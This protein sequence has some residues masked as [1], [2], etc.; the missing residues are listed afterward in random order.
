M[1]V[2]FAGETY[3]TN[4]VKSIFLAGPTPRSEDVPSWRP[5]ALRILKALGYDGD[6]FVPEDRT[7]GQRKSYDDQ[8]EWED[9]GLQRADCIVFWVP[10]ELLTMPAFTT[11]HE[12][13][14]W[15]RSGKVVL[16]A[17]VDAVKMTYLITKG[18]D[19]NNPFCTT[20]TATLRAA[21]E[22]IGDGAA[23][24]G[25]ECDV[26]LHVW[27]APAF[28]T[29]YRSQIEAGNRLEAARVEW[30]FHVGPKKVLFFA[31]V[32]V[33][34]YIASEN[35]H[36]TNEFVLC[37]PSI[38]CVLLY[39]KAERV[40]D[41]EVVL[42]REFRSPVINAQAYT[43]ELPGGSTF[44]ASDT[45]LEVAV[46]EVVDETTLEIAAERMVPH[47]SRQMLSTT[48][49][50]LGHLFSV[51]LTEDEMAYARSLEGQVFGLE[52][53]TERTF[54]EVRTVRQ[55]RADGLVDYSMLG[56]ILHVL[57]DLCVKT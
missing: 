26:P 55:L 45:P 44:E 12:H 10:R 38:S 8:V 3:P 31:A 50:S 19:E 25:A 42:V 39:R 36:K 24:T 17:P 1:R 28:Q 33:D 43:W 46:E 51:E 16:G 29:W 22:M 52:E 9:K 34:V 53:D 6:V 40:D 47:P 20:L 35:R 27:R 15:F 41:C 57:N 7:W 48:L 30:V 56:M 5:E 11:N 2:V 13:G 54:V 14:E 21:L 49:A 37:R 32:H 23:R 4:C 18:D